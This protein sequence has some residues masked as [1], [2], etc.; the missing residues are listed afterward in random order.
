MNLN[1]D[2]SANLKKTQ[3]FCCNCRKNI[4]TGKE[5]QYSSKILCEDCCIE[6]RTPSA[7]K[8]YWQYLSSVKIR[9][10]RGRLWV[11]PRGHGL[12]DRKESF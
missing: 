11:K 5:Y 6:I 2:Q 4:E 9:P 7:R 3:I 12:L 1:S 10:Q 8:T